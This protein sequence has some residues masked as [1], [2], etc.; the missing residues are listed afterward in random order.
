MMKDVM[1]LV[2]Y[3]LCT[4]V[5]MVENST[6]G[7]CLHVKTHG[8]DKIGSFKGWALYKVKVIGKIISQNI[9]DKCNA[10]GLISPCYYHGTTGCSYS[11]PLCINILI[12]GNSCTRILET[13]SKYICPTASRWYKCSKISYFF[14]TMH[15]Y[16]D[17]FGHAFT[18]SGAISGHSY[19][20]KF[21]LCAE[22]D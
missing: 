10:L 19:I 20:N 11:G 14:H 1:I 21:A 5:E 4:S 7:S 8:Y 15:N 22:K 9:Y 3:S 17:G 2:V 13:F 18:T 12:D 6:D 16:G